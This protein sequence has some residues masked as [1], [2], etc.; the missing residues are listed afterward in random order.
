MAQFVRPTADATNTGVWTTTPLW[1]KVNGVVGSDDGDFVT[2]DGGPTATETFVC[3]A[4][5]NPDDPGVDTGHILRIRGN[6]NTSG[7]ANYDIVCEIR[8]GYV[9]EAS[10]GTLIAT[11]S[12]VGTAST[13][14]VTGTHNLT[15]GEAS[16]ITN[17]KSTFFFRCWA[18]KN[19][20]GA[21]R[22]CDIVD[23]EFEFGDAIATRNR[24]L[25]TS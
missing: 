8:Q 7:G 15:T 20:G 13:T 16:T 5:N 25:I 23:V 4:V 14:P 22:A 12:I 1:S 6:K 10:L 21:N 24:I 3:A 2:S 11:A 9:S 19:G 18:V 17:Y